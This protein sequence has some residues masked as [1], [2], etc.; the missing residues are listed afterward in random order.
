MFRPAHATPQT[1]SARYSA[2][3]WAAV[4]PSTA[5]KGTVTSGSVA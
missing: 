2:R 4:H 5:A 1:I 3:W